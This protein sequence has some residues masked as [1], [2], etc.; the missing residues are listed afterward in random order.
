MPS[1]NKDLYIKKSIESVLNQKTNFNFKL[2]VTDDGSVDK[3][4]EIV[5]SYVERYPNKVVLLPSERNQGLLS[6]I[7][8]AYDYLLSNESEYFCCLDADDFLTDMNFYQKAVD[9]LNTNEKFN[10]Y[11]SNTSIMFD[12]GQIYIQNP[13]IKDTFIDSTFEDMLNDEAVLG[14]TVS[15]VFRNCVLNEDLLKKLKQY[16][17]DCY[18]EVS[19]REDD[20]RNRIHLENSKAHYVNEVV[21]TYRVTTRGLY[22]GSNAL[23]KVLLKIRSFIDMYYFFD[24]KYPRFMDLALSHFKR[25]NNEALQFNMN[26]MLSYPL[27]DINQLCFIFQK[28]SSYN[29][30]QIEQ[31]ISDIKNNE[32][33]CRINNCAASM[34][35]LKK[36][37]ILLK[38][39]LETVFS[40]K[41]EALD[42]HLF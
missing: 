4:I 21:G 17:G 15:S 6:N 33:F 23:K 11:T 42:H 10:I 25:I 37:K 12:N 40:I 29:R 41:N 22:Q 5:S 35:G 16:V 1:Y 32:Y 20:F 24:K 13:H 38:E 28:L 26:N 19:V 2:V 34:A 3:T 8:K 31:Y 30:D 14:N 39:F 7:I 9:F 27:E 18:S 36:E